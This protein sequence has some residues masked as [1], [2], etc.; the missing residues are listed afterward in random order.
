MTRT[1]KLFGCSPL[2]PG[3]R[4]DLCDKRQSHRVLPPSPFGREAGGEG[5]PC[6]VLQNNPQR[7]HGR[8]HPGPLPKGEG[9]EGAA[10]RRYGA[11]MTETVVALPLI[12][13]L[14]ALM[15]FFGLNMQRW[16]RVT[17]ASRYEAWRQMD[18]GERVAEQLALDGERINDLVF[19]GNAADVSVQVR[20]GEAT[21]AGQLL[22]RETAAASQ[23]AHDWMRSML[24]EA[25]GTR[26]VGV[27][28]SFAAP[29]GA[30]R[31]FGRP[32]RHHHVVLDGDWRYAPWLHRPNYAGRDVVWPEIHTVFYR[33]MAAVFEPLARHNDVADAVWGQH[34]SVPAY[35]GPDEPPHWGE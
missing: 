1:K 18:D 33:D 7:P 35:E 4:F 26:G 31:G 29:A 14:L 3:N 23:D 34:E 16:Q 9:E 2:P 6:D 27:E 15:L 30:L 22:E 21:A 25:P 5:T 20:H 24:A 13:V 11:A 28:A 10:R 8:P 17:M 19:A 12:L 32:M